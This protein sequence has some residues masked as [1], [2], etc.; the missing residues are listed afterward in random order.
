MDESV[1]PSFS[2]PDLIARSSDLPAGAI[3]ASHC[4]SLASQPLE[5]QLRIVDELQARDISVTV[6]PDASLFTFG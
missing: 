2:L 3:V 5:V 6:M 1:D 4:I